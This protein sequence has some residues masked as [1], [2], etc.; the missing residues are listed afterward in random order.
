MRSKSREYWSLEP[1]QM[2]DGDCA[3]VS[4]VKVC[5]LEKRQAAAQFQNME[6][7]DIR[8]F[9][10]ARDDGVIEIY[11]YVLGSVFPVLCYECK[12]KSTITGIDYGNIT[13]ANSKDVLLSCYDGR[14]I[15]LMDTKKFKKQGLMANEEIVM[16]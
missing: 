8:D 13:M 10:V 5:N 14:I 6:P 4:L 2:N 16:T 9:I 3:P 7:Q 12:I 1:I 15:T 11:A